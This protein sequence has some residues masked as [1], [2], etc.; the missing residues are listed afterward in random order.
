MG[1][2]SIF[3]IHSIHYLNQSCWLLTGVW[4]GARINY[5]YSHKLYKYFFL[6]SQKKS[7]KTTLKKM[8][9]IRYLAARGMQYLKKL[10]HY[11][12][13]ISEFFSILLK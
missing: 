4:L 11:S 9:L 8:T 3:Q 13:I 1:I 2:F 10:P 7:A 6:S 5:Y 12:G